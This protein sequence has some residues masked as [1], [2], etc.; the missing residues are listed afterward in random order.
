MNLLLF[1][2]ISKFWLNLKLSDI[3]DIIILPSSSGKLVT[4]KGDE[5]EDKI[6]PTR[7]RKKKNKQMIAL[8]DNKERIEKANCLVINEIYNS[9]H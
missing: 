8:L 2:L 6:A 4:S 7:E 3:W 1:I 5:H 9:A